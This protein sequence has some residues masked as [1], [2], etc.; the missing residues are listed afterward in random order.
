MSEMRKLS[1]R[2]YRCN[3]T[4]TL[5]VKEDDAI[6]YMFS[7]SRRYIQD[8]F[9]YLTPGERE[10]LISGTCETCFHEMFGQD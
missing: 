6:E 8:I 1:V 9:P 10:L 2:C 4:Y 5:E 7:N 3:K